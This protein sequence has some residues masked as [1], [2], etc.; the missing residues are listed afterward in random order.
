MIHVQRVFLISDEQ[1]ELSTVK[2]LTWA[3]VNIMSYLLQK[4]K[5]CIPGKNMAFTC[6]WTISLVFSALKLYYDVF[7]VDQNLINMILHNTAL[8]YGCTISEL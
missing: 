6:F 4:Q 5:A 3:E 7:M 8:Q 1:K 2:L